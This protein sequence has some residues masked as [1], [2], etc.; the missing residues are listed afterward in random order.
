MK[1]IFRSLA[2]L[3]ILSISTTAVN[4]Q[5]LFSR[6]DTTPDYGSYRY[7]DECVAAF[8]RLLR[9]EDSRNTVWP[10]TVIVDT[11]LYLNKRDPSI[12][13]PIQACIQQS[14]FDSV[15]RSALN[16]YLVL[17]LA[18]GN[19]S[20]VNRLIDSMRDTLSDTI[21]KDYI[22][23]YTFIQPLL[24]AKPAR[25]EL[26]NQLYQNALK[27]APSDSILNSVSLQIFYATHLRK[28]NKF[29]IS[30]KILE[31]INQIVDTANDDGY[32][33]AQSEKK[34]ERDQK[35][36]IFSEIA[37]NYLA[38]EASDS[39]AVSTEAYRKYLE[40]EWAS[41]VRTNLGD[42]GV[43]PIGKA[44]PPLVGHYW[45]SNLGGRIEK[46]EP[47]QAP[48]P[49]SVSII[50]FATAGCHLSSSGHG[51]RS[52]RN[53]HHG[54]GSCRAS[55]HRL[56]RIM[57]KHPSI[58]LVV[59]SSTYGNIGNAPPLSPDQEADSL[60]H[61]FLGFLGLKGK[62]VIYE[63]EFFRLPGSDNRKID[64]DT[65][66][67]STYESILIKPNSLLRYRDNAVV[68]V[69]EKGLIFYEGLLADPNTPF[70]VIEAKI[71]AVMSRQKSK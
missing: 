12:S 62:Q 55:I 32:S 6:P 14:K 57:E 36:G 61:Y 13:V 50:Y 70:H 58:N 28:I 67:K 33:S 52:R 44:A 2:L 30:S 45:Y 27:K 65:E 21:R 68:I 69:D 39:L 31:D 56:K 71:N 20:I 60:A 17:L 51:N 34:Y 40:R 53:G 38:K 19:D 16:D 35:V 41:K 9:H 48:T 64:I 22:V 42:E 18:S 4:A 47:F 66:N 7:F 10:D 59:A 11:T 49:G 24:Q 46:V 26:A 63:T 8:E 29:D 37:Y 54:S 23:F 3:S 43:G 25:L 15:A 5:T 1:Q